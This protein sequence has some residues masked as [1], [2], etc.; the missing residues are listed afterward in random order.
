M[1][2]YLL[3]GDPEKMVACN[4][5]SPGA[6]TV[7]SGDGEGIRY[8]GELIAIGMKKHGCVGALVD[9][10]IRDLRWIGLSRSMRAIA[11]RCSRSEDGR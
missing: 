11:R 1:V 9:G 8:F 4:D 5:V 10:G 3:G 6:V 2:P 7:W